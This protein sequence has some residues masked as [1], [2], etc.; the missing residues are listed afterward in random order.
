MYSALYENE[1]IKVIQ[2]VFGNVAEDPDPC[3]RKEVC[4]LII[5]VCND[6]DD[7]HHQELLQILDKVCLVYYLIPI[8]FFI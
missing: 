1:L 7:V 4:E 5:T 2:D 6:C 3:V 8:N